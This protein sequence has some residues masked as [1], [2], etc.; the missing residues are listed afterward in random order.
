MKLN[1]N[2]MNLICTL[3]CKIG[4]TCSNSNS[5]NG[6][7]NEYGADFRYPVTVEGMGK[8]RGTL[9]DLDLKPEQ[10]KDICY[11]FG[12]NKLYVGWGIKCLLEELE[13]R[14]GLDFTELERVRQNKK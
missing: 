9:V 11:K 4:R 3:E 1:Q 10:L 5:Y 12:S 14:Y 13:T 7:T 6:W 2:T 8:F